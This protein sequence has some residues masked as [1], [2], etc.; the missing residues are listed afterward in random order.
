MVVANTAWDLQVASKGRFVLGLGPQIRPHNEK[1]FSVPWSAPVPRLRDYVM[2]LRAIWRCWALGERLR[3]EGEHY[4]FTL[5]TP[6]FVPEGAGVTPI[7][8][9]LAAVGPHTLKLAGEVCDGVRLHPFCTR[10]YLEDAVMRRIDAGLAIAGKAR[11]NFQISGGGFIAT[12]KTEEAVAEVVEWVRYRVAFYG[13]T[14]SYWPVLEHHG[15]GDLGRK[16]NRMSKEGR[17]NEMAG[18]IPDDLLRLFTVVARHDE[19]TGA[20]AERY[21]GCVDM[22]YAS[23]SSDVRPALPPDLIQDIQRIDRLFTGF[24]MDW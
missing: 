13:S 22:V 3:F 23:I 6:N 12:G 7:P 21:G 5:M 15:E 11:E 19:L 4:R 8:V 1:R 14:P 17:W 24:D 16:L 9:T 20:I 18:E 2:A 10:S